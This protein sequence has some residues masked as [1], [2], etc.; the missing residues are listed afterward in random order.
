MAVAELFAL[1]EQLTAR[2][3]QRSHPTRAC[4]HRTLQPPLHPNRRSLASTMRALRYCLRHLDEQPCAGQDLG[5]LLRLAVT[6]RYQR[7]SP[8]KS[9]HPCPHPDK[10]PLGNPQIR[11]LTIEERKQLITRNHFKLAA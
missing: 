5:T 1:Q 10:K 4:G 11:K 9:R 2:R 3:L 8:K 7:K 6:D